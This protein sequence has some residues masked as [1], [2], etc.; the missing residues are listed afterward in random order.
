MEKSKILEIAKQYFEAHKDLK[1]IYVCDD[2]NVF[3]PEAKSFVNAHCKQNKVKETLVKRE[4][5]SEKPKVE[6]KEEAKPKQQI[7]KGQ[8]K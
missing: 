7:P 1:A 6:K 2:G 3:Y 5:L 8:I 4:D